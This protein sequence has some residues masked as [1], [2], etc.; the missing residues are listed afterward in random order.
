MGGTALV[1][2]NPFVE[3]LGLDW[4]KIEDG[5]HVHILELL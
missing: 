4:I 3:L 5:A 1:C 2:R